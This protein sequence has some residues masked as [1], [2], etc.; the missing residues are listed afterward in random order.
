[1]SVTDGRLRFHDL[2]VEPP[3]SLAVEGLELELSPAAEDGSVPFRARAAALGEGSDVRV[4]GRVRADERADVMAWIDIEFTAENV[5]PTTLAIFTNRLANAPLER[6]VSLEGR[7]TGPFGSRSTEEEP[8]EALH[9]TVRGQVGVT[10]FGR[11][12]PLSFDIDVSLDDRRFLVRKGEGQW[13]HVSVGLSGWSEPF[14]MGKLSYRITFENADVA[15]LL[16]GFGVEERWRPRATASGE[17]KVHGARSNPRLQYKMSLPAFEFD[18]T[19]PFTID[20]K[21]ISVHGALL[22]LNADVS[23]SFDIDHLVFAGAEI[24]DAVFGILYWRDKVAL[25]RRE[26]PIWGGIMDASIGYQPDQ[27]SI[28]GGGMANDMDAAVVARN[29]VP[30]LGLDASGRLDGIFQVGYDARG[31]WTM[32]RVGVHRGKLGPK[33]IGYEVVKSIADARGKPQ[34]LDDELLE[35]HRHALS[36]QSTA[37]KRFSFDYESREDGFALRSIEMLLADGTAIDA[38]AVIDKSHTVA[39][40]GN[41]ELTPALTADL[42]MRIPELESLIGANDTLRIPIKVQGPTA[43]PTARADDRFLQ[44]ADASARGNATGPFVPMEPDG[45]I[46]MDLPTLRE[47]FYR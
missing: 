40:W 42:T 34:A 27:G 16:A 31:P 28:E 5:E 10:V 32:G 46:V 20:A 45:S 37:F 6:P 11:T 22:A 19:P 30:G 29:L 36:P 9:G 47:Q 8:A 35:A 39:G 4:Q 38:E 43:E 2:T 44:A 3:T 33:G 23:A 13:A 7:A 26:L 21:G 41:I 18:G 1:V 15:E 24:P 12:A 17:L 25:N 14:A